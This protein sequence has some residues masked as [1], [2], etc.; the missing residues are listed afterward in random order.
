MAAVD[1]LEEAG[2]EGIVDVV[3]VVVELGVVDVVGLS[4]HDR[5]EDGVTLGERRDDVV[6]G[7]RCPVSWERLERGEATSTRRIA[8]VATSRSAHGR[9]G[10]T[11]A[12][13]LLSAS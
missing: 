7:A 13:L 12:A 9:G 8:R 11:H 1:P 4:H 5:V 2:R 6:D 3:V 10:L